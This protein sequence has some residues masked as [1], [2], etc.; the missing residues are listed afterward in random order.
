MRSA[1]D[2][3]ATDTD[4]PV[5]AAAF[6][7]DSRLVVGGGGG[8]GKNGVANKI[9]TITVPDMTIQATELAKN[10]DSPMS[11]DVTRDGF[12]AAG[13][14]EGSEIMAKENRNRHLRVFH[15]ETDGRIEPIDQQQIFKTAHSDEYQK[16]TRISNTASYI[17]LA[18]S[19]GKLHVLSFPS[20][21]KQFNPIDADDIQDVDFSPDDRLL[22]YTT[23]S[24]V[25]IVASS[26]GEKIAEY[27]SVPAA[28]F[29]GVRFASDDSLVLV[30]NRSRRAGAFILRL[31]LPSDLLLTRQQAQDPKRTM[32]RLHTGI[33]AA[34]ALD[35]RR[36][37]ACVAGA[38]L[39]VSVIRV[40]DLREIK[41]F[42]NVHTFPITRVLINPSSTFVASTSVAQTIVV[43]KLPKSAGPS[44]LTVVLSS[45]I[46][47]IVLLVIVGIVIQLLVQRQLLDLP[48]NLERLRVSSVGLFYG[49]GESNSK[50]L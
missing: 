28:T 36:I 45:T 42:R 1:K 8:E 12:I 5:Y 25:I 31:A 9:A 35:C 30:A 47:S 24:A 41:V 22:A 7:D 18:S 40:E 49:E 27:P 3:F 14:N 13:I 6:L 37:F 44:S 43:H 2:S 11:L 38:D 50:D 17:A 46:I 21:E 29:R 48:V 20:L 4:F 19:S 23:P 26:T 33:K 15:I 32:R 34:T 39:S 16:V 10:E